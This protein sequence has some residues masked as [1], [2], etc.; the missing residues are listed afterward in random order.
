MILLI[1]SNLINYY[2]HRILVHIS[3]DIDFSKKYGV[4]YV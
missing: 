2:N 1:D 4:S 3:S